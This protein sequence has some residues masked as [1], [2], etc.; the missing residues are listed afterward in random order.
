MAESEEQERGNAFVYNKTCGLESCQRH[1]ALGHY[2]D[3]NIL[4][5]A[6]QAAKSSRGTALVHSMTSPVAMPK[7][8]RAWTLCGT[9]TCLPRRGRQRRAAGTMRSIIAKA[10]RRQRHLNERSTVPRASP[11]PLAPF[12]A[13][14]SFN[15]QMNPQNALTRMRLC[16]RH[17]KRAEKADS[18]CSFPDL[19]H[20]STVQPVSNNQSGNKEGVVLEAQCIGLMKIQ[21]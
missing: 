9:A 14:I 3:N 1:N 2:L 18:W 8:E 15:D 16:V 21:I 10:A 17:S 6:W 19:G 4:S 12:D 7:A 11:L 20:P 13:C 5:P